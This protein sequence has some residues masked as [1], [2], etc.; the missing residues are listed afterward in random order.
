MKAITERLQN[1]NGDKNRSVFL[2]VIIQKYLSTEICNLLIR[3]NLYNKHNIHNGFGYLAYIHIKSRAR[4]DLICCYA[5]HF[6][7]SQKPIY[8]QLLLQ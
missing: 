3:I 5:I 2:K 6:D 1:F 8:I 4:Y 7:V